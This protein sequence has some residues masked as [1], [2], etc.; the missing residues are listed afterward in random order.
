VFDNAYEAGSTEDGPSYASWN[1]SFTG[2]PI[3]R[4]EMEEY[5]TF[6][7]GRIK[8]LKPRRV[9]EIGCGVGVLLRHLAPQCEAYDGRDISSNAIEAIRRW[10]RRPEAGFDNVHL[11]VQE[12]LGDW[13]VEE[14]AV[15]TII[16]N[17]VIQYFPDEAYLSAVLEQALATARPAGQ[18][19]VGNIL[20]AGLLRAFHTSVQL[21]KASADL[22][23][24]RLRKRVDE[25]LRLENELCV[26]PEY[27]RAVQRRLAPA[28]SV[29]LLLTRGRSDNE[30]TRYRYDV[31]IHVGRTSPTAAVEEISWGGSAMQ[32][33]TDL[34][35]ELTRRSP[36]SIWIRG[37]PNARLTRD[38]ALL[39]LL[40]NC[41]PREDVASIRRRLDA[42]VLAGLHPEACCELGQRLG[43]A[44]Q[45]APGAEADRFDL[46]F[47]RPAVP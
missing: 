7:I 23:A 17:S 26:K 11:S 25:M 42:T 27:F 6:T 31:V 10:M 35:T 44:V 12:A 4:E 38:F 29:E 18:I 13:G 8:A 3:P 43:Y 1:S 16:M 22:D 28:G 2:Q 41:D 14:G 36:R 37:V 19:F 21:G 40:E 47:S 32:R 5:F 34:M 9:L 20:H 33:P 30:L 24:D 45:V 15:D 39:R 46:L